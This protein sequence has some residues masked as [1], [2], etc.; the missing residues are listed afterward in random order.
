[1]AGYARKELQIIGGSFNLLP[2]PDKVPKTDYLLAQNWRV[3]QVG[4]LVSRF[5]WPEKFSFAA[6]GGAHSAFVWGGVLGDSYVG[7]GTGLYRNG[8]GIA[9][10]FDGNP[11]SMAALNEWLWVMNQ[12]AQGRYQPSPGPGWK[13]WNLTAPTSAECASFTATP[14]LTTLTLHVTLGAVTTHT[15]V[16]AGTTYSAADSLGSITAIAAALIAAATADPNVGTVSTGLGDGGIVC[17]PLLATP[18][19]VT[20]AEWSPATYLLSTGAELNGTYNFYVTYETAAQ[21]VESNPG[22]ESAAVTV[23][24]GTVWLS[25]LPISS[26]PMVGCRNVYATGGTLGQA[27]LVAFVNDNT[28]TTVQIDIT[29]LAATDQDIVMPT[30]NDAPPAC[31]GMGGPMYGRLFAWN[32]LAHPNRLFYTDADLPQYWPGAADAA[33]GNWVDVGMEGEPIL[34]CTFHTNMIVIYKARSIWWLLG[35]PSTGYLE[36]VT[37]A[38][39]VVGQQAVVAAG[40]VD[41]VVTPTGLQCFNL[42]SLVDMTGGLR[43]LFTTPSENAGT[44]TPPGAIESGAGYG[45]TG[46]YVYQAALGYAMGKLYL[47]YL[48]NT[49]SLANNPPVLIYCE[50]TGKWAYARSNATLT[51]MAGFLFD[52]V[53]MTGLTGDGAG[54]AIGYNLDDFRAF[55]VE[56]SGNGIDCVYQS[57]YEDC[58]LPDNEKTWIEVVIDYEIATGDAGELYVGYNRG[59]TALTSIKTL[60]A[61]KL[62]VSVPLGTDG[63]LA[64]SISVAFFCTPAHGPV[65]IHNVYLYYYEEARL[66]MAASTLPTDLGVGKVKQCKELELDINAALSPVALNVYSDL[67]GNALAVQA[68]ATV[69]KGTGR[70][71]MKFPLT[72]IPEGYLWRLALTAAAGSGGTPAAGP[73]QLYAARLLMRV[74]GV[75]V[76]AYE[77]AGGFVWDSMEMT[78][79]TGITRV[80]RTFLI[81]LAAIP[82]KR[83]REVTLEIE[84]FNQNVTV[85]F[86]TDLP[87]NAQAVRGTPWTVNTGTAGRRFV[88]LPLPGGT[89]APVEGRLCR[90]QISGSKKFILYDAA[91]ECLVM[92]AYIEAYEAAAGAVWD[93]R[94]QDFGS[95][96][97]KECREIELD[98][99]TTGTVGAQI[100][101][102]LPGL[103]MIASY[104]SQAMSTVGRQT[105]R[106]PLTR[107]ALTESF[108]DGRLFRLILTG[109]SA[110]RLYGARLLIREYGCYLSSDEAA[111]GA[112]W[113][114]TPVDF[115]LQRKKSY[116]RLRLD[117]KTVSGSPVTVVVLTS[118][119]GGAMAQQLST[120]IDTGGVR[121]TVNL[122]L[123]PG[124]RG[125][126]VQV[127]ISGNAAALY[128]VRLWWRPW[129]EEQSAWRWSDLPVEPTVPKWTWAPLPVAPTPPGQ[130]TADPAQWFWGK[131]M[132]VE[133]T[134]NVWSWVDVDFTV[135]GT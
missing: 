71:L 42:T 78:F 101:S 130:L 36:I 122:P 102:D 126:L 82:I 95:K 53:A 77:A 123:P 52:G 5:G 64:K 46:E 55:G 60:A 131:V 118:Q 133:E 96:K 61:G 7:A 34:N 110:Y 89:N 70:A 134:P 13:A 135:S 32:T 41:Y 83:F 86:L 2:P 63:A 91:V 16:L 115:E 124:V 23:V 28:T 29:D 69:P 35:D 19:S 30:T 1:M 39:G 62:Q 17:T 72:G 49:S 103:L 12:A 4:K 27:Y 57:H 114:S 74:V 37:D 79:E 85:S 10:G 104:A 125:T 121:G 48:E 109:S 40:A 47:A 68:T 26:D 66:A 108:V 58:G 51:P 67:P 18:V 98:I 112:L 97:A 9:T 38:I 50:Q 24:N 87:G 15:L 99:E 90:I 128:A 117:L 80:P 21:D 113:D 111:G 105:I 8:A 88:R 132:A 127:Q 81:A 54:N 43:P 65:V 93:S 44:L 94:E 56:D 116:K 25:G 100:Y 73:F 33:E 45:S 75:Y 14:V 59:A 31:L 84:T 11:L 3:D 106:L 20:G 120:T 6:L 129:N 92:G 119:D 107:A 76:E 22:P